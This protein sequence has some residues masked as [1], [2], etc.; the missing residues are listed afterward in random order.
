MKGNVLVIFEGGSPGS[1]VETRLA[2]ARKAITLDNLEK[3]ESLSGIERVVVSTNY[4]DLA[5]EAARLGADVELNCDV[6]F[7]VG[8]RLKEIVAHHRPRSIIYMGG[9]AGALLARD[10]M[11]RVVQCLASSSGIIVTNNFFSSDIIG[12]NPASAILME[13]EDLPATDN[14]LAMIL[15]LKR[16]L[17]LVRMEETTGTV[18]DV[19]TPADAMILGLHPDIGPRARVELAHFNDRRP[20]LERAMEVLRTPMAGVGLFGRVNPLTVLHLNRN[21]QCR[22]RVLSEERGM[23]ALD[24]TT[25]AGED[26]GRVR[27]RVRTLLGFLF[28]ASGGPEGFFRALAEVC[29]AAFIDTRILF[30][31]LGI[32]ASRA[33]RFNSDLGRA[34][35]VADPLVRAI[36]GA[37]VVMSQHKPIL[38]GGHSLVNGGIRILTDIVK[39][40][41]IPRV[42]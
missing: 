22:V 4:A 26:S 21:T 33:D 31:H 6:D 20:C 2:N 28:E 24:I 19:D 15:Q 16:G 36:T 30:Y 3:F 37:A 12:L 7:H 5:E 8:R 11:Q 41:G 27:G 9:G 38:L 42:L 18:F 13:D 14:G 29:D 10:E 25:G 35:L 32:A 34:G 17:A 39:K 23:K 1:E 40:S